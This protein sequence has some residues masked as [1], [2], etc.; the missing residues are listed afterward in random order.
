MFAHI[1]VELIQQDL[2]QTHSV[3]VTIENILEDRL[4]AQNADESVNRQR[5]SFNENDS[6]DTDFEDMETNLR[7]GLSSLTD[8]LFNASQRTD[9]NISSDASREGVESTPVDVTDDSGIIAKYPDVPGVS[10]K[11]TTLTQRKRDLILNS[12]RRF[13]ERISTSETNTENPDRSLSNGS[14]HTEKTD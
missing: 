5:D 13:L 12:K 14:A 1:P 11:A 8:N 2:R 3:E 10:E 9:N 4:I 6:D 7:N